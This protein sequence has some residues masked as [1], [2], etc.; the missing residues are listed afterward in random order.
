MILLSQLPARLLV[1]LLSLLFLAGTADSTAAGAIDEVESMHLLVE[2]LDSVN[3][4]SVL[5]ALMGGMLKGLEGRR[6]VKTPTNW[7]AVAVKLRAH[8]DER[9]RELSNQLSQIFGDEEAVQLALKT[10]ADPQAAPEARRQMLQALLSQQNAE[11]SKLLEGLLDDP[12]I[13]M[14]A[15]RGYAAVENP[16][17]P[18]IL[19]KRYPAMSSEL[20]RAVV[21]TLATR[22][23][24]AEALLVAVGEDQISRNDIPIHVARS[25][26]TLHHERF[27]SVFGELPTLGADREKQITKWKSRI[28]AEKLAAADPANGRSVFNRTCAACHLLYG[29]G[30]RIGPNLTGSNRANL[31]YLLLNSVDPS[32]DVP[33]AY[34]MV[35]I[36]TVNGRVMNGV[37]AEEDAT[38]VVLKTVENPRLVIAKADIDERVVSKKSMMPD[39]QL[40]ALKPQ[41]LI[42]LIKYL[43][44]TEQVEL[45]K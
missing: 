17:A 42:D 4:A 34:K 28:T 8:E 11:A 21:E 13:Q 2:A 39:G 7:G 22:K 25:L 29:E 6:D 32:Y 31:D 24:Y 26:N 20:R 27:V 35:T 10:V 44:T 38:R 33:A 19:L 16:A 12:E 14:N 30:G 45:A 41:E 3:E 5:R 15:I 23:P 9:V 1:L 37:V 40:D 36:V 18:S 43:Q